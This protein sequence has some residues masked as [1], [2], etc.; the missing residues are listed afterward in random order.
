MYKDEVHVLS[1]SEVKSK[2]VKKGI[3][4]NPEETLVSLKELFRRCEEMLNI[5]INKVILIVPS[6][7]AE[8]LITEGVS[9]ITNEEKTVQS[10][11]IIRVLQ[12]CVYNKVPANKEFVSVTPVEF[13]IN[14]ENSQQIGYKKKHIST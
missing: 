3:I 9:T 10:H 2:G 4:V 8:F 1:V 7:Y 11:D 12:A 14:D 5:T 6:Y 13:K